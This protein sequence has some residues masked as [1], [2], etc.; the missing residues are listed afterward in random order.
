MRIAVVFAALVAAR[1]ATAQSS[2]AAC[3]S[4]IAA[5]TVDHVESALYLGVQRADAGMLPANVASEMALQIGS[6]FT[7]PKPFKLSVFAGP[8]LMRGLRSHGDTSATLRAPTLTGAYRAV[9]ARSAAKPPISIVRLSMMPGFDSAA[10]DAIETAI[11]AGGVFASLDADSVPIEVTFSTDS[12]PGSHR[13]VSAS[14]PRMQIVDA[15]IRAGSPMPV[16]PSVRTDEG[17][18]PIVLRFVV[19]RDGMPEPGTAEVIRAKSLD[20]LKASLANLADQRFTPASIKGC[21]VAQRVDL[22]FVFPSPP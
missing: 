6:A 5:S 20:L 17:D 15:A 10:V 8:S 7:P 1:P 11:A 18:G 3:D 2:N 13:M 9:L 12:L 16:A 19:G 14:F 21:P 22:P 4:L